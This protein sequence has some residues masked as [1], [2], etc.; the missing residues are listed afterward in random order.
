M[1]KVKI[2]I[3]VNYPKRLVDVLIKIH[4]LQREQQ[5]ELIYNSN[6]EVGST[7]IDSAIFLLLDNKKRGVEI[8]T[9]KYFEDGCKVFACKTGEVDKIDRFEF[10]MTVLRVWPHIIEKATNEEEP[11]LYTFKYGKR[12][13]SKLKNG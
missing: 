2:H 6:Y 9:Q 8:T 11:C 4:E 7:E 3:D 12:K 13:L 5:Y 1:R 10:S